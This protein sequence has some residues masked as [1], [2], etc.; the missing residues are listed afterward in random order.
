MKR[1]IVLF[2]FVVLVLALLG[3]STN[4]DLVLPTNVSIYDVQPAYSTVTVE[5]VN[6]GSYGKWKANIY[7][8]GVVCDS[9]AIL[10][11]EK[12]GKDAIVLDRPGK[13]CTLKVF[14]YQDSDWVETDDSAVKFIPID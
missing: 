13:A 14:S 12:N 6:Y 9:S 1:I 11:I 7:D 4:N 2:I 5:V 8:D 10:Y 3:C